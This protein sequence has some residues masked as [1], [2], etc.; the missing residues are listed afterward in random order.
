MIGVHTNST[1]H[2]ELHK[3]L[4]QNFIRN[5]SFFHTYPFLSIVNCIYGTNG[6]VVLL[7]LQEEEDIL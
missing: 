7:V 5:I 4:Y 1:S 3:L 2:A 6:L